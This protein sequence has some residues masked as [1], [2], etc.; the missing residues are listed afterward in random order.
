[1]CV[2][3]PYTNPFHEPRKQKRDTSCRLFHDCMYTVDG[4]QPSPKTPAPHPPHPQAVPPRC[5]RIGRLEQA[6][7]ETAA[8][9]VW[10]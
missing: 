9:F 8:N 4:P 2:P 1:M 7:Q 5:Q 10:L 3:A 6:P